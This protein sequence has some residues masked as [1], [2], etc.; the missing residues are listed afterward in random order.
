MKNKKK[1]MWTSKVI[2]LMRIRVGAYQRMRRFR[3]GECRDV[4]LSSTSKM[5]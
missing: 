4:L 3:G 1:K 2:H 5:G